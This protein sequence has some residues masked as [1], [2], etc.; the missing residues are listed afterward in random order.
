MSDTEIEKKKWKVRTADQ[1]KEM[2]FFPV[3]EINVPDGEIVKATDKE[4]ECRYVDIEFTDD[5][6]A[7]ASMRMNFMD[8]YMFVYYVANEE[9]RQQ[10]LM[11]YE[12]KINY[13][14]YE[15]TFKIDKEEAGLGVAK[16]L[17]KLPVD[18]IMMAMA[19]AGFN[20]MAGTIKPETVE[21]YFA[22]KQKGRNIITNK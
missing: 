3:F 14:P 13:I 8:L 6:G 11:R 19:R 20:A 2:S 7:T 9:L 15:V 21:Q 18:D 12:R 1:T 16:R 10:L 22:R 4:V 5:K 17:I